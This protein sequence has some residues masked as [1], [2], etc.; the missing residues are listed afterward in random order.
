M[1][2]SVGTHAASGNFGSITVNIPGCTDITACNYDP[3]ATINDNS[4]I[5]NATITENIS[6]VSCF[7]ES[8]GSVDLNIVGGSQNFAFNWSISNQNHP[9]YDPSCQCVITEDITSL[10]AGEYYYTII[11][12]D[13]ICPNISDSVLVTEPD[14][15]TASANSV[16]LNGFGIS[17]FGAND[18]EINVTTT[19]GAGGGQI[20]LKYKILITYLQILGQQ[21]TT[22]AQDIAKI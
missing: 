18:G 22:T 1:T 21:I 2:C 8:N 11:D 17:C 12:L 15:L 13:S 9:G 10:L 3:L 19:G 7:N 5:Y 6:N 16:D 4:C 14:E 20:L